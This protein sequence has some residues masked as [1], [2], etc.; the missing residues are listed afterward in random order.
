MVR[1]GP[2]EPL[3]LALHADG[4]GPLD[5]PIVIL[6]VDA[7]IFWQLD[8]VTIVLKPSG[9]TIGQQFA[10]LSCAMGELHG[11]LPEERRGRSSYLEHLRAHVVGNFDSSLV[12]DISYVDLAGEPA[13]LK[14]S[15]AQTTVPVTCYRDARDAGSQGRWVP[16][17]QLR[18]FAPQDMC[19]QN[20]D[21]EVRR[22]MAVVRS[23]ATR[24]PLRRAAFGSQEHKFCVGCTS[25][26]GRAR[27][28]IG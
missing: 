5:E 4:A 2:S 13:T 3:F 25:P 21:Q 26:H 11:Y 6:R 23:P 27:K 22:L 9:C 19:D 16:V 17:D 7:P 15:P 1:L 8:A 10:N 12:E 28:S 14:H 24:H 18:P 20:V